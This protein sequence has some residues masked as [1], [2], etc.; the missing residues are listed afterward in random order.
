MGASSLAAIT[1]RN[2]MNST[3][4]KRVFVSDDDAYNAEHLLRIDNN[5]LR[6][7]RAQAKRLA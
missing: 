6:A 7:I 4:M 2:T 3:P 1:R 5:S